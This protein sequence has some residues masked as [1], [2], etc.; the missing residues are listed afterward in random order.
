[1]FPGRMPLKWLGHFLG[2]RTAYSGTTAAERLALARHAAG[3]K[4][5]VEIGVDEGLNSLNLRRAM[6]PDGTLYLV[7][8]YPS[9]RLGFNFSSLIAHREVPKSDNGSVIFVRSFSYQAALNWD[10]P[11]DF[12]FIDGDHSYEGVRRDWEDW[13]PNVR[14]GGLI[15]LHD[16]CTFPGGSPTEDSGPVRLVKE[17]STGH[18]VPSAADFRLVETVDSLSVFERAL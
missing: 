18:Q 15:A 6:A 9:G 3:R 16:S 8:P 14:R 4:T 10:K 17:I 1:M 11:L 12:V 2:L 13:S 7:D 5:L